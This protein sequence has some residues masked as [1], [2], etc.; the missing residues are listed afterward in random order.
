M[1]ETYHIPAPAMEHT[2]WEGHWDPY[3][4]EV[5][6][7]GSGGANTSDVRLRR[8]T[9]AVIVKRGMTMQGAVAG[10][11]SG[12]VQT[13]NRA[14]LRAVLAAL[15]NTNV[16]SPL[17][18][19]TDSQYVHDKF[20]RESTS[21]AAANLAA[22]ADLWKEVWAHKAMRDVVVRKVKAH[23]TEQ[24]VQ[25]GRISRE[26]RQGNMLADAAAARAQTLV[27]VDPLLA[28]RVRARDQRTRQI[29]KRLLAIFEYHVQTSDPQAVRRHILPGGSSAEPRI[30][31]PRV[32][33]TNEHELVKSGRG[34]HCRV[35][36]GWA[37]INGLLRWLR[38][39][40]HCHRATVLYP[41]GWA[42]A[43]ILAPVPIGGRTVHPSHRLHYYGGLYFC[44]KCGCYSTSVLRALGE[45]CPKVCNAT[46]RS[47]LKKLLA[48]PP[49]VPPV[50]AAAGKKWPLDLSVEAVNPEDIPTEVLY[51]EGP[52]PGPTPLS[53]KGADA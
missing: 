49:R 13:N 27:R 9:W 4:Q 21:D 22:N 10:T 17:V 35:C 23:A 36:K 20:C 1:P 34:Y 37:P 40:T 28:V 7:D 53:Y 32:L 16:L 52:P 39:H 15:E 33:P 2:H 38:E 43:T 12:P 3:C 6:T 31:V 8:A 50:M 5:Y 24:D 41:S 14:E 51:P 30:R 19:H 44:G 47:N 45:P 46:G 18:A 26:D 29:L 42:H 11:L 25:E 48:N